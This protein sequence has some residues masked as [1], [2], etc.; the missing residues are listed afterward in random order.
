MLLGAGFVHTYMATS[1]TKA[2]PRERIELFDLRITSALL[3]R[4]SHPGA[5]G[6]RQ[7]SDDVAVGTLR[8]MLTARRS[9]CTQTCGH[10][11]ENAWPL[12]GAATS[13]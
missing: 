10:G 12:T 8:P 5:T 4:L 11:G 9:S 3:Y 2:E 1:P 7:C 13:R 6:Q